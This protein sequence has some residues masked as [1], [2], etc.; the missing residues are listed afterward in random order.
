MAHSGYFGTIST[1]FGISSFPR[2]H[3]ESE[4]ECYNTVDVEINQCTDVNINSYVT[5]HMVSLIF[6]KSS[7][8]RGKNANIV[9]GLR[10]PFA[11]AARNEKMLLLIKSGKKI[12]AGC[13]LS[14]GTP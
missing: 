9:R 1:Q 2:H 13:L 10:A 6:H 5:H 3:I 8:Q 11:A 12:S 4:L 7:Q 14:V